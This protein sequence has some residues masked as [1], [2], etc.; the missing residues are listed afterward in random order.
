MKKL[1]S[2]ILFIAAVEYLIYNEGLNLKYRAQ[3]AFNP[4]AS[5]IGDE[6]S[7]LYNHFFW[8]LI[9]II[10]TLLFMRL[11]C[12][13]ALYIFKEGSFLRKLKSVGIG[14]L[15]G[16]VCISILNLA[17]WI[18]GT[19]VFSYNGFDWHLIPLI[20]LVF[21]QCSA[22]EMLLRGYVPAVLGEKHS[23]DVVC[24][25]SGMLFIFHHVLN[26]E[27]YGF[28]P[29]YCLNIFLIGVFFCLLMKWEGNFWVT[30]GVHTGWNYTQSFIMG[31]SAV[32]FRA[33]SRV[34]PITIRPFSVIH[35]DCR[36]HYLR[37]Y[38]SQ[39]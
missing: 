1:Y 6:F 9:P 36:V 31:A 20:P 33:S 26:M 7:D 13:G 4:F 28:E 14:L 22:E 25:V 8:I 16:F 11:T 10:F 3:F 12:P 32:N 38:W 15:L 2:N 17:S 5:F 35:T 34:R 23:W 27:I 19:T 29:V 18:S 24:F 30:C 21:I 39:C 37:P